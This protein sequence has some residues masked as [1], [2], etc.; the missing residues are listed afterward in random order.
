MRLSSL[1]TILLIAS[2]LF[3]ETIKFSASNG[4]TEFVAVGRPAMLKIGGHTEGPEG[5][6]K[7][8]KEMI[9]GT[10][11]VDLNKL[12]TDIELRDDHMKNKYLEVQKYPKAQLMFKDFKTPANLDAMNGKEVEVPFTAELILKDKKQTVTGIA[13]LKKN[14]QNL[15][16]EANFSF[17]IMNHLDTLPSYA[18]IKVAEDVKVKIT[19]N[20]QI[21]K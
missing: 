19:L 17:K 7:Y 16:G 8:D 21:A 6:L 14:N 9:N 18:G 4:K 15:S 3:A 13:L 1:L 2:P 12:T 5:D 10:L 11:V 20:G